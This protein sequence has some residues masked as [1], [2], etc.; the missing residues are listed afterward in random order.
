MKYIK[1]VTRYAIMVDEEQFITDHYENENE[2]DIF[3]FGEAKD[4]LLF[5]Y[6][7]AMYLLNCF[8]LDPEGHTYKTVRF[9]AFVC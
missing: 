9:K 1:P 7:T 2:K 8:R 3:R 5:D 6:K 4:L